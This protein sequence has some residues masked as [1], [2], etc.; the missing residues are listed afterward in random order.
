M[1]LTLNLNCWS[2]G[3]LL[4][5]GYQRKIDFTYENDL[6]AR[7]DRYYSQGIKLDYSWKDNKTQ[8]RNKLSPYWNAGLL[9][10]VFTPSTI[11]SDSILV[12]DRPYAATFSFVID[13]ILIDSIKNQA[14]SYG[15][16]VGAVGPAARGE[17]MQTAIHRLTNNFLPLGWQYQIPN[18]LIFNAHVK[19]EFRIITVRD[20]LNVNFGLDLE[21]G[22]FR[23]GIKPSLLL[24]AGDLNRKRILFYSKSA[25]HFI[26]HDGTLQ[27]S[28][29]GKDKSMI[30]TDEEMKRLVFL[31]EFGLKFGFERLQFTLNYSIQS[32]T[33][34]NQL[35]SFHSWGGIG[36]SYS[37]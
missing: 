19:S 29:V 27:G 26:G 18:G 36:F 21:L 37:F 20:W 5:T 22:T 17:E 6:F 30:I 7:T 35:S 31:Q 34:R 16:E 32:K 1:T 10:Q 4:Q 14:F 13:R 12:H 15:F 23:T 8:S 33:F 11:K 25:Y 28:L 3:F 24:A 2:Q 9:H